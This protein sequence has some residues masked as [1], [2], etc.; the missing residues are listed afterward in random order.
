MKIRELLDYA[1]DHLTYDL[2]SKIGIDFETI[3]EFKGKEIKLIEIEVL[4]SKIGI[5]STGT[6]SYSAETNCETLNLESLK[7]FN[8]IEIYSIVS[9]SD[10]YEE[11]K[12][13][14]IL[15]RCSKNCIQRHIR[16]KKIERICS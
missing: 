11:S 13:K 6:P 4:S 5:S 3:D 2:M 9:P 15:V 12:E 10:F 8:Y 16:S 14:P 7:D 1:E